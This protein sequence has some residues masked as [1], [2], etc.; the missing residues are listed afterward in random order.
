MATTHGPG[1]TLIIRAECYTQGPQGYY[2]LT[3]ILHLY[4]VGSLKYRPDQQGVANG[5]TI[6]KSFNLTFSLAKVVPS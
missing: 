6:R 1:P 2:I 4:V 5:G 3:F